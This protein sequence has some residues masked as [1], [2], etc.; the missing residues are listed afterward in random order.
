[1]FV[2]LEVLGFC[3][4]VAEVCVLEILSGSEKCASIDEESGDSSSE[5][6]C[7]MA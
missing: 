2:L 6:G 7:G 4:L 5:G 1:M 3:A